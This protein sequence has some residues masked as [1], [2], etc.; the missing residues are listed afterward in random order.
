MLLLLLLRLRLGRMRVRG[1]AVHDRE[2]IEAPRERQKGRRQPR[3]PA[4]KGGA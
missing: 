2:V 1:G 3:R 4:A